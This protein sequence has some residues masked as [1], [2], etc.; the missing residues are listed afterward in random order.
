M[1]TKSWEVS[2][3]VIFYPK[4]QFPCKNDTTRHGS[5]GSCAVK[6]Q[7]YHEIKQL[8][9]TTAYTLLFSSKTGEN[10]P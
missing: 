7:L 5:F 10:F 4:N 1:A 3:S 2:L 8:P 6:L 9:N